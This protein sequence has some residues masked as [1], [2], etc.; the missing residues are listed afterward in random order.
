[1][2]FARVW[3]CDDVRCFLRGGSLT[4]P[5]RIFCLSL[6]VIFKTTSVLLAQAQSKRVLPE[7]GSP[8]SFNNFGEG[9]SAFFTL[10]VFGN[11][12]S[13]KSFVFSGV[14]KVDNWEG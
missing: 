14:M 12:C 4:A 9:A 11:Y 6:F 2:R 8:I 3:Q 5:A 10:I 7:C 1:M 13:C